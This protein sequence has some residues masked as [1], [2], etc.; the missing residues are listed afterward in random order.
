MEFSHI[1]KRLK[2]ILAKISAGKDTAAKERQED[3]DATVQPG[4]D[5]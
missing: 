3:T 5:S 4:K 1:E 2:E